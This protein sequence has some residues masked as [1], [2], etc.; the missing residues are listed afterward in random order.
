MNDWL[1]LHNESV[2]V[3]AGVIPRTVEQRTL[4]IQLQEIMGASRKAIVWLARV[5]GCE[6]ERL[7]RD[8]TPTTTRFRAVG[9]LK[10]ANPPCA[11]KKETRDKVVFSLVLNRRQM[12]MPTVV[13]P[14]S[15]VG[16]RL[17]PGQRGHDV[18]VV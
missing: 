17:R 10:T 9:I 11:A 2:R 5:P 4:A 1:E 13:K 15:S 8:P 16:P 14:D 7:S 6:G 3:V 12:P 18:L